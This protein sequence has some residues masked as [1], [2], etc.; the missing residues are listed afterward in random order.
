MVLAQITCIMK[1]KDG[2]PGLV[3][4]GRARQEDVKMSQEVGVSAL[5]IATADRASG[6]MLVQCK[7]AP[8]TLCVSMNCHH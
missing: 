7:L 8:L 3:P 5:G 4:K 2:C 1:S 6:H